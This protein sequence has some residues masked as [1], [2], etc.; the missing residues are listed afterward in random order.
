MT[1]DLGGTNLR[2]CW[3][4]LSGK[5]VDSKITQDQFKLPQALKKGNAEQLWEHIADSLGKFIEDHN[6]GGDHDNPLPLG[7]TFSY[8]AIQDYIDHGVLQTWTKGFDIDKV[9]GNDV[10]A[11]LQEALAQRVSKTSFREARTCPC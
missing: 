4:E 1:L 11:Q 7:F 5:D 3:I 9:E 6:L 2:V 8:P 10:A